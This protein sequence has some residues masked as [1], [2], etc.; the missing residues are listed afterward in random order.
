MDFKVCLES[1]KFVCTQCQK[2]GQ[3]AN[4]LIFMSFQASLFNGLKIS[5]FAAFWCFFFSGFFE[6]IQKTHLNSVKYTSIVKS[7]Q[8]WQTNLSTIMV[9]FKIERL[10]I[11]WTNSLC[12]KPVTSFSLTKIITSSACNPAFPAG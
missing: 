11:S 1:K 4:Y 5:R 8:T 7:F 12:F 10:L 9:I 6:W 2:L 3:I